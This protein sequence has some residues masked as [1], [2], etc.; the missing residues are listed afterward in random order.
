[1]SA[2]DRAEAALTRLV[3]TFERP[4]PYYAAAALLVLAAFLVRL[5]VA[6]NATDVSDGHPDSWVYF[7]QAYVHYLGGDIFPDEHRGSG[8]Q[9]L[10]FATLYALG[11]A[12]GTAWTPYHEPM[13]GAAAEAA[14][15]AHTLSAC[16]SVGAVAATL[17]LARELLPRAG[18]LLAATLVAFDP[19]LL[20]NSTSA[21]SE[22]LYVPLF[23]LAV[24]TVLRARRHPAWLV[25]TGALMALAHVM[26]VNG[27]V[28]YGALGLFALLLLGPAADARTR[29]APRAARAWAYGRRLLADRR[30]VAWG[31]ASVATFL[32]VASPYLVWREVEGEGAFDYGTNQRFWTDDLW[33]LDDAWW[34]A[35][36]AGER[37]PRESMRDYFA[38]HSPAHAA[39]RL[40]ASVGL[41][42][43][44]LFGSGRYPLYVEEGGPWVGSPR[45]ESALTPL[46]AA[47]ALVAAFTAMKRR[48]W[49]FLP[50]TLGVTVLT[51]LWIYPLVRSVRYWAP[52]IPLF[53]LAALAGWQHLAT[54][55]RRPLVIGAAIFGTWLVLYGTTA[56]I[57]IPD[58]LQLLATSADA[59][60]IA[61]VTGFVW[62]LVALAPAVEG[63]LAWARRARVG[64]RQVEEGS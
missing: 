34:Q 11:H 48:E 50:V 62:M 17:L 15:V 54:L 8:W 20:R 55:V 29:S 60:A 57:K 61:A 12:P 51:F 30:L 22:P 31:A 40:L 3:R 28:M 49:W 13:T 42:I 47:L 36:M 64:E 14:L 44:D 56:L 58:G 27:L 43:F 25:A 7:H 6:A 45:E 59:R 16:L 4:G 26:R 33:D 63:A 41:Q 9:L 52:L 19:F 32:L 1:M 5:P 21:M 10:L 2:L 18:A 35:E 46:V 24:L 23:V 39:G 38:E 53:T 37:I